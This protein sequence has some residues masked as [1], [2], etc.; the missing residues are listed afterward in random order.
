MTISHPTPHEKDIWGV[1]KVPFGLDWHKMKG[2]KTYSKNCPK[3]ISF[4]SS[5]TH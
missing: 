1:G 4:L 5:G 3:E 2:G